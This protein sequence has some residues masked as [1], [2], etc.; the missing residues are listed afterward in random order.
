MALFNKLSAP[1]RTATQLA[2]MVRCFPW[3]CL[4]LAGKKLVSWRRS[5][6]VA[7]HQLLQDINEDMT[8]LVYKGREYLIVW[9][10][11]AIPTELEWLE[12]PPS[13]QVSCDFRFSPAIKELAV[14]ILDYGKPLAM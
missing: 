12:L 13:W 14:V 9:Q 7:K 5:Q 8:H 3:G 2:Y 1:D 11:G 4:P 10:F 6:L